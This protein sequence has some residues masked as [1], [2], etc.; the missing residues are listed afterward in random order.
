MLGLAGADRLRDKRATAVF[1]GR[2]VVDSRLQ[3]SG[4]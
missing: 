4:R 3:R 2:S 1:E